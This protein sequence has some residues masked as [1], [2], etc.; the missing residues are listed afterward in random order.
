MAY[1][2]TN[3]WVLQVHLALQNLLMALQLQNLLH[4]LALH[5]RLYA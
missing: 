2:Y 3:R 5:A 4:L 1:T